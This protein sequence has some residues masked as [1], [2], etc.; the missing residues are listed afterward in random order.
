M[1]GINLH[2]SKSLI[3]KNYFDSSTLSSSDDVTGDALVSVD[4]ADKIGTSDSRSLARS[5]KAI[6]GET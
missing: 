1:K 5:F 4:V 2:K 6:G 3:K